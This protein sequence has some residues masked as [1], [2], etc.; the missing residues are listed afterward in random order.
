MA[1]NK[2][3]VDKLLVER[4][5]VESRAR[6]QALIMAGSVFAGERRIEKPGDQVATD[7]PLEVRGEAMPFVSRGGLKLQGALDHFGIDVKGLVGLDVGAS[8]GGFTDCLLQR[9]AAKVYAVDV[10][11]GQLHEKLRQDPRVISHERVNAREL[12][13]ELVPELAGVLVIDVS[14]ISL[15]IVL[16]GVVGRLAPGGFLVALVKPQFEVG[17]ADVAHGGVV[18][19]VLKLDVKGVIDASIAGPAGNLEALLV[20]QRPA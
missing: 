1:K 9:G 20:A 18:R 2:E 5:L 12:P 15:R 8:T 3:R 16:P 14:F 19:D 13:I 10:G 17:R 11:Y 7:A 4:N 6:A